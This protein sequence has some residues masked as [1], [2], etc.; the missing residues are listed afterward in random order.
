ME[1]HSV[2]NSKEEGKRTWHALESQWAEAV[3]FFSAMFQS[4]VK[5]LKKQFLAFFIFAIVFGAGG[6]IYAWF[7]K[8]VYH[9]QMTVSYAHLEKKIYGDM[10][11]KLN[12]LVENKQYNDLAG[13]LK[14]NQEQVAEIKS[15]RGVNIHNQELTTDLSVEKVPFYIMVDVYD[16]DV[17]EDMEEALVNYI[18][19][20]NFVES[21]LKLNEN[22]YKKEIVHLQNQLS[23]MDSLKVLL[24]SD[25]SNLEGDVAKN[26]NQLNESQNVIFARIKDLETAL[27]F[28][29]NIEVMDGFIAQH[30]SKSKLIILYVMIGMAI[31][32]GFRILYIILK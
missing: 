4:F 32:L 26:L 31:G 25:C 20:S 21:R 17:L 5:V 11:F 24:M 15:I 22:N 14:M 27:K 7:K 1:N 10:L 18:S 3:G 23:Y 6:G 16:T 13:L 28:N 8:D 30:Q 19:Q 2:K 29:K 12:Q 9:S